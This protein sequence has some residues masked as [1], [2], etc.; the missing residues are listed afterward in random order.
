MVQVSKQVREVWL[1]LDKLVYFVLQIEN[2]AHV[3]DE[4]MI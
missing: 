4:N 1:F 2:H 3:S